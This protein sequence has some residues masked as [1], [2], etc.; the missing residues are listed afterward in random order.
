M[1]DSIAAKFL[2]EKS[3]FTDFEDCFNTYG[4][5]YRWEPH[6]VITEDGYKLNMFRIL[7]EE[8]APY[9]PMLIQHGT[10]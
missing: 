2:T 10:G 6:E 9:G 5:N 3:S 8:E 7:T 1:L 4:E